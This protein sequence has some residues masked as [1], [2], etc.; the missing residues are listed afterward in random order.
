M[1]SVNPCAS[2]PCGNNGQC[3]A[4]N[5]GFHCECNL[6]YYGNRCER[7]RQLLTLFLLRLNW[8]LLGLVCEPNPCTNGGTCEPRPNGVFHCICPPEYQGQR[9]EFR[10]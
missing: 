7:K 4:N 6:G 1:F 9:C 3:I 8:I 2:N 10:K 5:G